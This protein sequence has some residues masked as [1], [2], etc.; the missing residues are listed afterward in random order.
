MPLW[1]EARL[2][3]CLAAMGLVAC[4][5]VNTRPHLAPLPDALVDTLHVTPATVI[6]ELESLTVAE[7]FRIQVSAPRE[8]YLETKW[9]DV[10]S[11]GDRR[12]AVRFRFFASPIGEDLTELITEAVMPHTMDPSLPERENERMIP[13]DHPGQVLVTRV[14]RSLADR[15]GTARP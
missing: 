1:P 2:L 12:T 9:H 7:G 15:H 8:G 5:A 11:E 3:L 6:S 4:G 14:L 10:A 13:D